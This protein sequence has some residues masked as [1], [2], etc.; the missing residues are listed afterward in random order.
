MTATNNPTPGSPPLLRIL[1]LDGDQPERAFEF[2][3][4]FKIGRSPEC[5]VCVPNKFLSRCHVEVV[6]E[7]AAWMVRDLNSSNGMFLGDARVAKYTVTGTPTKLRL[8]LGGPFVSV[9]MEV[10]P[11]KQTPVPSDVQPSVHS[12]VQHYFGQ[13]EEGTPIGQHTMFVRM[14]FSQVQKRQ[15]TG[16][17]LLLGVLAVLVVL[18]SGYA[19]YQHREVS[20]Q[21]ALAESVF[22]SV[23]ALDVDIANFERLAIETNSESWSSQL[24]AY[25]ERRRKLELRYLQFAAAVGGR[26]KKLTEQQQITIRIAR[27]FGE[28]ELAMPATFQAEIDKYIRKWQSSGRLARAVAEAN[29]KGYTR[30][31]A[32][33]LLAVGLPPQF[34]YLALQESDFDP[35]ISGPE[36][37]MGI[38]KGMWQFVPETAIKYGMKVGPLVALRRP[39]PSDD[40]H[41][42]DVETKAAAQYMRDLYASDAQASGL[43]VMACYN[44]GEDRV[45]PL[46]RGL[47]ANPEERNF[48]KIQEKFGRKIPAETY[49]Y[50]L[51]IVSA[52]IIGENPRLFGFD[53]DNPLAHLESH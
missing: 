45:L 32:K 13:K 15:R 49:D 34:F 37:H 36:T 44:W 39:D 46:V 16:W 9:H 35:Y 22:Y 26:D 6:F 2:R 41:H 42:W 17:L 3:E 27:I 21:R 23:K 53:F 28:C 50:V 43:L 18:V 1:V 5:A 8:G 33:E 52:A 29:Q 12:Y 7:N 38:A 20:K 19:A 11:S 10:S 25:Q 31:I 30:T 40:R 47:P 4:S 14:A 48:W 24:R 51:S